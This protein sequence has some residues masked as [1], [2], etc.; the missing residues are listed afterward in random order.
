MGINYCG[1]T[2]IGLK[3][4]TNQDYFTVS[5]LDNGLLLMVVCDGMGGAAGGSEAS[6]IAT[7][8]FSEYVKS[9][10]IAKNKDEYLAVLENA[11]DEANKAVCAKAC[12]SRELEGMGTTLVS[13]LY[14]G[15]SYYC[16]WVGDSRIYA[17]S[18]G[19][20]RQISHDHSFVQTL[21][22]GGSITKDE[23]RVHPNRNI[24]TRA[25]GIEKGIAGDVCRLSDASL[26]GILLCSDGLCG[27][28]EEDVIANTVFGDDNT[29]EVCEK[30]I[31]LANESGGP[32][33]ITVVIHK[34]Q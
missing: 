21:V 34:K 31:K 11:L 14:D 28:V 18:A 10:L 4:N 20:L 33:N 12:S 7:G 3:R 29:E 1:K 19:K 13:A 8:T 26:D 32:D 30:L 27:Y 25:V 16:I 24:I 15:E 22:D 6:S 23:A 2:D 5:E 17:L 9:H